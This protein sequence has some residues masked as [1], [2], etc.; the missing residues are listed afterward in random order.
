MR[1][2]FFFKM[3]KRKILTVFCPTIVTLLTLLCATVLI[4]DPA[5]LQMKATE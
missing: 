5:Q 2:W 1:T 4:Y 3:Q